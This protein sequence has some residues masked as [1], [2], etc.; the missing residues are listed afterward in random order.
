M[1]CSALLDLPIAFAM[2]LLHCSLESNSTPRTF[3]V[4]LLLIW[5]LLTVKAIGAW[6]PLLNK[7]TSVLASLTVSPE[8]FSHFIITSNFI[9]MSWISLTRFLLLTITWLSSAKAQKLCHNLKYC[10][11][12]WINKLPWS[13][14][15]IY[16]STIAFLCIKSSL[17]KTVCLFLTHQMFYL[18][19][20]SGALVPYPSLPYLT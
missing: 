2:W 9:S 13:F 4:V 11:N 20:F 16:Y 15:L 19:R 3:I 5:M 10:T 17:S 18:V 1:A 6:S 12:Q 14:V 8:S 7:Q